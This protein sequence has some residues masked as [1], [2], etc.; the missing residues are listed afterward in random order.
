MCHSFTVPFYCLREVV[1]LVVGW[2]FYG[3]NWLGVFQFSVA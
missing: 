2:K 3:L 1:T